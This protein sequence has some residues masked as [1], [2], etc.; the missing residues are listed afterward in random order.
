MLAKIVQWRQQQF[1]VEEIKSALARG[2]FTTAELRNQLEHLMETRRN[3]EQA[4][5]DLKT[6]IGTEQPG[7]LPRRARSA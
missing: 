1:T 6:D 5:I 3:I 7:A 2:G 4:I